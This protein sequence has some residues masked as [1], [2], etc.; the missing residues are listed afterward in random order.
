MSYCCSLC[1]LRLL[2]HLL[3]RIAPR[4][5]SVLD[6]VVVVVVAVAAVVVVIVVVV[7]IDTAGLVDISLLVADQDCWLGWF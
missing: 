2:L 6:V 5:S 1:Y 7:V 3:H 4:C